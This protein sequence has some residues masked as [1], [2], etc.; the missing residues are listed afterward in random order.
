MC[1]EPVALSNKIQRTPRTPSAANGRREPML[2]ARRKRLG[3]YPLP[4]PAVF[5][6]RQLTVFFFR[7]TLLGSH[8]PRRL[9]PGV[10]GTRATP[11]L[12]RG[13]TMGIESPEFRPPATNIYPE[14]GTS[15]T[16]GSPVIVT[17]RLQEPPRPAGEARVG[18]KKR[19]ERQPG[20][21]GRTRA[22]P[23]RGR[24]GPGPEGET[25]I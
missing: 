6:L 14:L 11:A 22:K 21:A 18:A 15:R 3:R 9:D 25:V 7:K 23:A 17:A 12:N 13:R 20:G 2:R 10:R 8:F 4:G 5:R 1:T 24:F 19:P 16:Q